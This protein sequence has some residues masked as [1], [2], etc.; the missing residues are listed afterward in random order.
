MLKKTISC[1]LLQSVAFAALAVSQADAASAIQVI[2]PVAPKVVS[3]R[4]I[5]N[6]RVLQMVELPDG[7]RCR[8][9]VSQFGSSN[10]QIE[11]VTPKAMLPIKTA[12][13]ESAYFFENFESWDG[14]TYDWIPDGWADISKCDPP[15]VAPENEGINPTWQVEYPSWDL[16]IEGKFFARVA[17]NYHSDPVT[18]A[19]VNE[20][21]DEWLISPSITLND[22]E[23]L[24]FYLCY[25]PGWVFFDSQNYT[26][27]SLNNVMEVQVS[28]DGGKSWTGIW[29]CLE[30]A[31]KYS[32]SE[33]YA[34][35]A[36]ITGT[37]IPVRLSLENYVGKTIK[38]AFRYV[39]SNG[40]SMA[41]DCV[42]VKKPSPT[43]HY[44]IPIG[45]FYSGYDLN[46]QLAAKSSVL[47]SP[48]SEVTFYNAS[49]VDCVDFKWTYTTDGS[50]TKQSTEMDLMAEYRPGE[51]SFPSLH[52]EAGNGTTSDFTMRR[53]FLKVGGT[54][55]DF[56]AGN[57][58]TNKGISHYLVGGK[59]LFGT[60]SDS[61]WTNYIG[62]EGVDVK[63]TAICNY[64]PKPAHS[65]CF[66]RVWV[67]AN[68]TATDGALFTLKAFRV[69]D[70]TIESDPFAVAVCDGSQI[71]S[72]ISGGK[73]LSALPFDFGRTITVDTGV[74]L[75]LTGFDDAV[76]V[77][78][79]VVLNQNTPNPEGSN[80][81]Y[82]FL[83]GYKD[84]M[85]DDLLIP[86][87]HINSSVGPLCTAFCFNLDANFTWLECSDPTFYAGELKQSKG[88]KFY[89][90]Y[91]ADDFTIEGD[92]VGDWITYK[93]GAYNEETHQQLVTF[94]VADNPGTERES[95][96]EVAVPGSKCIVTI[97]QDAAS[98][99]AAVDAAR[100]LAVENGAIVVSGACG[101]QLA[102]YNTL[103][104][105]VLHT[106]ITSESD[107]VATGNLPAGIYVAR[108]S[109]GASIKFTI[110]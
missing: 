29:S 24:Y 41:I 49:N 20:K 87:S 77:Q 63:L 92:G 18:G 83:T 106:D 5:G 50:S 73:R 21:Q 35:L 7:R 110:R 47:T 89:T 26:M 48:F 103:G 101:E 107:A 34:S 1:L 99:V 51:Y 74:F 105:L 62:M 57:Y 42:T 8:R 40:E 3:S 56:G 27:T 66:G 90:E 13:A 2:E 44:T 17:N 10:S 81:A 75:K 79:F 109:S 14:E 68:V 104:I 93:I 4:D 43:A 72:V 32:N 12:E 11:A 37:W 94:T 15:S 65:Y 53:D 55:G 108:L 97:S 71:Q 30:D 85:T 69:V 98:G 86:A 22:G 88:L 31:Q 46:S 60:G 25:H 54:L 80:Y 64:F 59:Y 96:V 100:K 78:D 76:N 84:G 23:W 61:F 19:L 39:G 70:G 82:V 95:T 6:D 52:A 67:N 91:R 16:S 45:S 38:I 58:D 28:D 102:I 33:L 9:V 36:S